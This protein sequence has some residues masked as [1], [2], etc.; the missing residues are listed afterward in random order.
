M[1]ILPITNNVGRKLNEALKLILLLVFAGFGIYIFKHYADNGIHLRIWDLFRFIYFIAIYIFPYGYFF[2]KVIGFRFEETQPSIYEKLAVTVVTGY[3]ASTL[4]CYFISCTSAR[5]IIP[6]LSHGLFICFLAGRFVRIGAV[7]GHWRPNIKSAW[8][9]ADPILGLFIFL[10]LVRY[11]ITF[12]YFSDTGV[13]AP[14]YHHFYSDNTFSVSMVFELFRGIPM[15]EIPQMSGMRFMEY[16]FM[17]S[18]FTWMAV[19]YTAV[20]VYHTFHV[21]IPVFVNV[22]M[23]L[24]AH[25]LCARVGDGRLYGYLGVVLMFFLCPPSIRAIDFLRLANPITYQLTDIYPSYSSLL[26]M[27]V[28]L[29]FFYMLM[30]GWRKVN[31]SA[32]LIAA[33]FL[34]AA[35]VLFKANYFLVLFPAF[36][37]LAATSLLVRERRRMAITVLTAGVF[38]F[39]LQEMVF[40]P[41]AKDNGIE[42]R[43]GVFAN[44]I[45]LKY[46]YFRVPILKYINLL[47]KK[48]LW[49]MSGCLFPLFN[50][51]MVFP[52][53]AVCYFTRDRKRMFGGLKLF[54]LFFYLFAVF[55][56]LFINVHMSFSNIAKNVPTC[57][58]TFSVI[59]AVVGAKIAY[60]KIMSSRPM[61]RKTA[62][63][64]A[65]AAIVLVLSA[66][67]AGSMAKTVI[68]SGIC[69]EAL[70]R[71]ELN[72]WAYVRKHT[73]LNSV[74]LESNYKSG[75]ES[76]FGGQ[77]TVQEIRWMYWN[78]P[79]AYLSRAKDIKRFLRTQS[80]SEAE[81]ILSKYKVNYVI[82]SRG[83][84]IRFP[85]GRLLAEE[86]RSGSAVLYRVIPAFS[87]GK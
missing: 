75:A 22:M 2:L 74:I 39:L 47:P 44:Y 56:Y 6:I 9:D 21:Y 69:H 64:T 79:D 40:L 54:S 29:A 41:Y 67:V 17:G 55:I 60:E 28:M 76:M 34:S 18:F 26:A 31:E 46:F 59:P 50:S 10:I 82:V 38:F 5:G 83:A 11:L 70:D 78:F 32:P 72:V 48:L 12:M 16:H 62:R 42:I 13:G 63:T 20:D 1:D 4:I 86:Y 15:K 66:S 33:C 35:L 43:Y 77:R 25:F 80:E 24:L 53:M 52:L 68:P 3:V 73:P 19:K 36:M 37:A 27:P 8:K 71:G 87:H 30:T 51:G 7:K 49:L 61:A 65:A 23:I 57:I 58:F 84:T 45:Y 14:V 85:C 81:Y